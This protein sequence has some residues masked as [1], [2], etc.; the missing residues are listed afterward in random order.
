MVEERRSS[1]LL[2]EAGIKQKL[3]DIEEGRSDALTR[4]DEFLELTKDASNLYNSAIPDE[5][6]DFVKKLTSNFGVHAGNVVIALKDEAKEIANRHEVSGSALHR[7]TH[8]TWDA[9]LT[10]LL[11]SFSGRSE[12][13]Q[14]SMRPEKAAA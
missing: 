6:R 1:L 2:E 10:R 4:L 13:S 5:K 11:A 9:I 12:H 3:S 8:R 7:G 14:R